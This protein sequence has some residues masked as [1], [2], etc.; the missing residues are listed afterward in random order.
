[1]YVI[2]TF[3]D[4]ENLTSS[5]YGEFVR[6]NVRFSVRFE[7]FVHSSLLAFFK[8]FVLFGVQFYCIFVGFIV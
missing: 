1:M 6:L 8:S 7:A 2:E 5:I 3:I 4:D